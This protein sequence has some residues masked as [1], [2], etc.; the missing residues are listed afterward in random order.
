MFIVDV[1][2]H[3]ANVWFMN[4]HLQYVIINVHKLT[5]TLRLELQVSIESQLNAQF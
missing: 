3:C 4:V 1:Q 2:M 5:T